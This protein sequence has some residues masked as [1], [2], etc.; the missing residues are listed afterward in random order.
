MF[1]LRVSVSVDLLPF[2]ESDLF[3]SFIENTFLFDDDDD[4]D[5]F[6]EDVHMSYYI[7]TVHTSTRL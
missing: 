5:E 7:Y 1:F 3:E 4:D 6:Y 2:I